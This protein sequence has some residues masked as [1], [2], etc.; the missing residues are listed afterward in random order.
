MEIRIDSFRI[1]LHIYR[2]GDLSLF[3][4]V[5]FSPKIVNKLI[6]LNPSFRNLEKGGENL[7]IKMSTWLDFLFKYENQ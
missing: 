4:N 7:D 2:A 5:E 3:C 6:F 1:Y